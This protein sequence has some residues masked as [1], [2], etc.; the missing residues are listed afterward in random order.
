[1]HLS[2]KIHKKYAET[3]HRHNRIKSAINVQLTDASSEDLR[4][5]FMNVVLLIE[6]ENVDDEVTSK[7]DE[8]V[9]EVGMKFPFTFDC[10]D[11]K[12]VKGCD[13]HPEIVSHVAFVD[14]DELEPDG[15]VA[16]VVSCTAAEDADAVLASSMTIEDDVVVSCLTVE[17]EE[18]ISEALFKALNSKKKD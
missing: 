14:G 3:H 8:I 13:V 16:V 11:E 7:G 6:V 12:V 9:T 18:I 4:E 1:M 2:I 5:K 15:D 17:V 10:N